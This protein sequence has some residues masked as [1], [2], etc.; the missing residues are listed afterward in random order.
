MAFVS[1]D[2]GDE[3]MHFFFVLEGNGSIMVKRVVFPFFPE[4]WVLYK[5]TD[6][7]VSLEDFFE[8]DRVAV[9]RLL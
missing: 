6:Q 8:L 5:Q 3:L 1:V 4:Q 9:L 7:H 2:K